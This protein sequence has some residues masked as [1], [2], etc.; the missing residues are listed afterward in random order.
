ML[1]EETT[2]NLDRY[3][4][5]LNRLCKTYGVRRLELFGSGA[6]GDFDLQQSDLDF[7]VEFDDAGPQGAFD[8][9]FG[10]KEALESLFQ[11]PV[12]LIEVKAI[13]NPY[14][15]EAIAKDKRSVYG[16]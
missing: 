9:F 3:S 15:R 2:F 12:D 10:F 13:S 4:D 5:E 7:L 16:H 11:R 6:R 8:R 14:F 1:R